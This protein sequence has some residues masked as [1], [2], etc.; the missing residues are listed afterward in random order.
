MRHCIWIVPLI[1]LVGSPAL[2]DP[3][4]L[5]EHPTVIALQ[6]AISPPRNR[7]TLATQLGGL[8]ASTA[9]IPTL[10]NDSLGERRRFTVANLSEAQVRQLEA[11]LRVQGEHVSVWVELG[12]DYISDAELTALVT[13]FD[14]RIYDRVRA[15]WG[16]EMLPGIDGD[17]RIH[18][19]F[20]R[21]LGSALIAYYASENTYPREAVPNSNERDMFFFNADALAGG[22]DLPVVESVVAHEFQH[23]IRD[24]VQPN[25]DNWLDEGLSMF[26]Q[27]YLYGDYGAAYAFQANPGTQLNAWN[28]IPSA[29]AANYGAALMFTTYAYDRFGLGFLQQVS[30]SGRSRGLDAFTSALEIHSAPDVHQLFADWV[31]ANYLIDPVIGGELFSYSLFPLDLTSPA[32]RA[33]I[34]S[35]PYVHDGTLPQ[36]ATDYFCLEALDNAR[37]LYVRF[38]MPATIPL[39]DT[40]PPSGTRLWYSGRSDESAPTLTRAFDLR[41]MESATLQYSAWHSL[42][43]NWDYAYVLVSDDGGLTWDIISSPNMTSHN[44]YGAAYGAAYNGDSDGWHEESLSLDV[45]AGREILVRFLVVT[46]D[47]VTLPGIAVDD[48]RVPELSYATDFEIDTGGWLSEGWVWVENTLPQQ[49]WLQVVQMTNGQPVITRWLANGNSEWSLP[50][51]EDVEEVVIAVS[52]FAPETLAELDY[53]LELRAD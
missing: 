27:L 22:F 4:S 10:P 1:L 46:D 17:P 13:A 48:V 35:F 9:E 8:I 43:S 24:N 20:A 51:M 28:P 38:K 40:V 53:S 34:N 18:A 36:Y 47:A 6:Q 15:L 41:G 21:G 50:L 31:L 11:V 39:L 12:V 2:A 52:P 30:Q 42:E 49:V 16:S 5:D 14:E 7:L 19:L 44:P 26:T 33:T 29:R 32:I 3:V 45:Y 25:L 23:M 37:E